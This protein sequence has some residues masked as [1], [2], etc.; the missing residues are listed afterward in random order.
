MKSSIEYLKITTL[1]ENTVQPQAYT[2][3]GQWGLSFYLDLID[4]KGEERKILLDTGINKEA[5]L[6]NVKSLKKD[7]SILDC[8]VI[9][10]GHLDHTAATVEAVKAS[11]GI[12]VYAHP[13]CFYPKIFQNKKGKRN[14]IG[15]PDGEN[16]SE[17]E[18]AGGTIVLSK[19]PVEIVPGF[20]TTGEVPRRSFE[21]WRVTPGT[22]R[23]QLRDGEEFDD[24]L[25]D[26]LSLWGVVDGCGPFVVTGCAHAG[27]V[28]TLLQVQEL[29]GSKE[30]YG[31]TGGTH[32]YDKN[33]ADLER[34]LDEL[35]NFGLK[36]M[37][38]CHCTGFQ[39][40]AMIWNR[41]PDEFVL[42]YSGKV[43][44]VPDKNTKQ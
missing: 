6:H 2:Q 32:M 23:I 41:F 30:I 15:V 9:S 31:F 20:W 17:I 37:S 19:D 28:N 18:A 26:D 29:S 3:L 7:L 39:P 42:N 33:E 12:P 22:K 44:E 36:L 16:I 43:I 27:I 14:N 4:S 25:L 40:T 34:T 10:H 38:P 11:G 5:L 24:L 35:E 21:K 8:V 1:A 13:Y